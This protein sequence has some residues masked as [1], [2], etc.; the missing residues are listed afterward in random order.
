ML[1]D[2]HVELSATFANKLGFV[3]N[4]T[5]LINVIEKEIKKA[6]EI[7]I[8]PNSEFDWENFKLYSAEIE[9]NL[10]NQI[11]LV[12]CNLVV[13]VWLRPEI[14]IYLKIHFKEKDQQLLRLE[15]FTELIGVVDEREI[16]QLQEAAGEQSS[17]I[18]SAAGQALNQTNES[19]LASLFKFLPAMPNMKLTPKVNNPLNS[20]SYIL[21]TL[22]G[23]RTNAI[24]NVLN[25]SSSVGQSTDLKKLNTVFV[26]ADQFEA[27]HGDRSIG[28]LIRLLSPGEAGLRKELM[29]KKGSEKSK[30]DLNDENRYL[31]TVVE[32]DF[33]D[34]CPFGSFVPC[35]SL[36]LQLDLYP[37]SKVILASVDQSS[38]L[39][40]SSQKADELSQQIDS[41][42]KTNQQSSRSSVNAANRLINIPVANLISLSVY[43]TIPNLD[44]ISSSISSFIKSYCAEYGFLILNRS[45]LIR[46]SN[47]EFTFQP[48]FD[49]NDYLVLTEQSVLTNLEIRV[50]SQLKSRLKTSWNAEL[51][52]TS[53]EQVLRKSM[54]PV[55]LDKNCVYK[56]KNFQFILDRCK[57]LTNKS[58]SYDAI[59]SSLVINDDPANSIDKLVRNRVLL[60]YGKKGS[61]KTTLVQTL[62]SELNLEQQICS[63]V[64]LDCAKLKSKKV[65][66]FK[67]TLLSTLNDSVYTQP[68]LLIIENLHVILPKNSNVEQEHKLDL[69]YNQKIK[70]LLVDLIGT[71]LRESSFV[72][73]L[74]LFTIVTSR[75]VDLFENQNLELDLFD[76][77]LELKAPSAD[78]SI[79]LINHLIKHKLKG[80]VAKLDQ[81]DF[82]ALENILKTEL[83]DC[84]PLDLSLMS[85]QI[86]NN[87]ILANSNCN[88]KTIN[89]SLDN[90][91]EV[92][93]NYVPFNLRSIKSG[94]KFRN[95]KLSDLG[96][97][98][99]VKERLKQIIYW[100]IKYPALFKNY[101][102]EPQTC[103]LLYGMPGTGK[104][105]LAQ[106]L[107]NEFKI[108]F[109]SIKGPEILSKYIGASEQA[110]RALFEKASLSKPCILFFDE[111][112]S[113][114]PPRQNNN[115]DVTD[116]IVNQILT[117]MD[118]IESLQEGIYIIAATSR[119]DMIDPAL[120]RPGRFD[121]CLECGL[122]NLEERIQILNLLSEQVHLAD[123][124]DLNAIAIQT[125]GYTGSDLNTLIINASNQ[126]I[127]E[128][129]YLDDE[130]NVQNHVEIERSL[131]SLK[132]N[133]SYF[134]LALGST[135]PSFSNREV[136]EYN[137]M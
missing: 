23:S 104:T 19:T 68:C 111:F 78:C 84:Q 74:R 2:E 82:R 46:Y 57:E 102:I 37:F 108:N 128:L 115:T 7:I 124:V 105:C 3:D 35:N 123:D 39:K 85:E 64:N 125:A 71:Y 97:L 117:Q 38:T 87:S 29:A 86:I 96:G 101:P 75:S 41:L 36:A 99:A 44:Q 65:D 13:P 121:V 4:Q 30:N 98:A 54:V 73:G 47:Y 5:V 40:M 134:R 116:R 88:D 103:V 119:P 91:L 67:K 33:V 109:I 55:R 12:W 32:V 58:L 118:G 90:Y 129:I 10:L 77:I 50:L 127:N 25:G 126:A 53:L 18:A 61:G 70:L 24:L 15:T 83:A 43:Q 76:E 11:K 51:P 9:S 27:K 132:L 114:V 42:N 6:N 72:Y 56:F 28:K 136:Q 122:P 113:I 120:L 131:S 26:N 80:H 62:T 66:L 20:E 8:Q 16:R 22:F 34:R 17:P 14:C 79:H 69:L 59:D 31:E 93:N 106:A 48:E 45:T 130:L 49:Q 107:A 133:N 1:N 95:K 137:K 110:I 60:I 52:R 112:D 100:P 63:L 135:S 21:P 92:F 81:I 89:F 94:N